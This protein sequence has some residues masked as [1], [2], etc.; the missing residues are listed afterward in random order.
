L[1]W[2]AR[3]TRAP[4]QPDWNQ[5]KIDFLTLRGQDEFCSWL[6]FITEIKQSDPKQYRQRQPAKKIGTRVFRESNAIEE[7]Q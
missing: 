4:K 5:R 7:R 6:V 3:H 2:T 1:P